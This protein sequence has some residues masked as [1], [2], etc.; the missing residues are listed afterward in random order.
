MYG[1]TASSCGLC[2]LTPRPALFSA[3]GLITLTIGENTEGLFDDRLRFLDDDGLSR[4]PLPKNTLPA[5]Q[6]KS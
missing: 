4:A 5:Q 2:P 6:W 3:A 1:V